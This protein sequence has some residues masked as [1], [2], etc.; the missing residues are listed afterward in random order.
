MAYIGRENV[1]GRFI[2]LA[3]ISGSFNGSTTAFTLQDS[4][5]TA[6]VPGNEENLIIV[7]SGIQQEPGVAY[8][9]SGSTITFTGQPQSSDTFFG[10]MLGDVQTVGTPTDS[11]VGASS[12]SSSFFVKNNQT[13]SSISMS[14]SENGALVGTVTVSGTITIP[15]GSTFVIL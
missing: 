4:G 11:T 2:K 12:L 9:V 10:I 3:D 5:G 13:W 15:S 1:V 8:T 7:I 14:G 6:V